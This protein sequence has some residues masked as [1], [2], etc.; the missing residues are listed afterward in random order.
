MDNVNLF[1]SHS[2]S[3]KVIPACVAFIAVR[4]VSLSSRRHRLSG[5]FVLPTGGLCPLGPRVAPL[6][7]QTLHHGTTE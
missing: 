7:R 1:G 2:T 5:S 4:T 6:L 3:E